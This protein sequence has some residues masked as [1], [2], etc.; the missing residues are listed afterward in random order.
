MTENDLIKFKEILKKAIENGW[1]PLGFNK[2]RD[3]FVGDLDIKL[4][5][6]FLHN[7][8]SLLITQQRSIYDIIF[9]HSFAKAFFG[10][11]KKYQIRKNLCWWKFENEENSPIIDSNPEWR[12]RLAIMVNE[13]NPLNYLYKFLKIDEKSDNKTN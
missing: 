13:E 3:N 9:S 12:Y 6:Y 11:G 7:V 10:N 2:N 4:K 8:W 5:E 1:E